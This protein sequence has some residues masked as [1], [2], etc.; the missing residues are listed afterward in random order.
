MLFVVYAEGV[1]LGKERRR[2]K[3]GRGCQM[4]DNEQAEKCDIKELVAQCTGSGAK[5]VQ[6][7]YLAKVVRELMIKRFGK[8][9]GFPDEKILQVTCEDNAKGT[10]KIID[11]LFPLYVAVAK[12]LLDDVEYDLFDMRLEAVKYMQ[13]EQPRTFN[14]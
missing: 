7:E 8:G 10:W 1:G 12:A 13:Q 11:G 14:I 5:K 4:E 2:K 9:S 6:E 3:E